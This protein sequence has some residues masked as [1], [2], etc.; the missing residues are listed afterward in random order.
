[1]RTKQIIENTIRR[2][3][4]DLSGMLQRID[5]YHIEGSLTDT[6]REEL[7]TLAR[8]NPEMEIDAADE[9][10]RLWAAINEIREQLSA[11]VSTG[12]DTVS[13]GKVD[14]W[15]E[16]TGAHDAYFNGMAMRWTDGEVYDCIAPEGVAVC[17]SP[18]IMP[19]YWR[20]RA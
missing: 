20:K 2:G 6:E 14:D 3:G 13:S 9:I 16:V 15:H 17:W 8:Q 1:M 11:G 18:D 5:T 10:N 4:Y 12:G 19:G 7:I